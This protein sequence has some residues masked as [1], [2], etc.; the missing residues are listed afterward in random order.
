MNILRRKRKGKIK[1][2]LRRFLLIICSFIMTT[3]A[4]FAYS[5]I[6]LSGVD[7]HIN[8]WNIEFYMDGNRVVNP[9]D[10]NLSD[11]YPTM[12]EQQKNIQIKN[13]GEVSANIGYSIEKVVMLGKEYSIINTLPS[14]NEYYIIPGQ[15]VSIGENRLQTGFID[16]DIRFPFKLN[17]QNPLSIQ[18][19]ETGEIN[20]NFK[21]DGN[22]NDE[23]DSKWGYNMAKYFQENEENRVA[24]NIKFRINVNQELS[25]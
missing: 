1:I 14:D 15:A 20:I 24:I 12:E 6:L 18:P 17:I 2:P 23:L 25:N 7:M 10:I 22:G 21:W 19:H 16:D 4:W 11:I 3:F 8:S 9:I 13:N 5:R